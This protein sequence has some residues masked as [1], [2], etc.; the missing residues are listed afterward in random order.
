MLDS[1]PDRSDTACTVPD[2]REVARQEFVPS[3]IRRQLHVA[4]ITEV[5]EAQLIL[6]SI[7]VCDLVSSF[8]DG[9]VSALVKEA[10]G[11]ERQTHRD[12][13]IVGETNTSTCVRATH[14]IVGTIASNRLV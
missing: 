9:L 2:D 1:Q 8:E 7:V 5:A 12:V 4:E 6:T 11:T 13:V 3:G 14:G 10:E